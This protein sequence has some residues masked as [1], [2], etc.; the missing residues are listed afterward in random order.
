MTTTICQEDS[1]FLIEWNIL[2]AVFWLVICPDH[3]KFDH[4]LGSSFYV[5]LEYCQ[6]IINSS[7][8]VKHYL[9]IAKLKLEARDYPNNMILER[10]AIRQR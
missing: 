1:L 10:C 5:N 2:F 7:Q 4:A 8:A 9:N 6:V 3:E